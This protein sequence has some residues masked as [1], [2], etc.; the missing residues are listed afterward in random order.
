MTVHRD[1][2]LTIKATRCTNYSNLFLEWNYIFRT[3]PLSI[4]RSFTLN[5]QQWYMSY[6]FCWQLASRSICSCSQAVSKPVWHI[7]LLCVLLKIPDDG[8]RNCRKHVEF[9]SKINLVIRASSWFYYKEFKITVP[10]FESLSVVCRTQLD[11]LTHWGRVTQICVF[12]L[13]LRKTD[14]A[15]LCF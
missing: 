2:F 6:R 5:T 12:S 8:Q 11:F 10:S 9:R 7:S 14:D 4:I 13:Q 1:T 15:N 3:V